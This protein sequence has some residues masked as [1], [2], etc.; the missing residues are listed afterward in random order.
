MNIKKNNY[1]PNN[2][3]LDLFGISLILSLKPFIF[4]TA[5]AHAAIGGNAYKHTRPVNDENNKIKSI[6][7]RCINYVCTSQALMVS[8]PASAAIM[9][10]RPVPVPMSKALTVFP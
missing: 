8:A 6:N 5:S 2:T 9:D 4:N 3:S 1:L 10:R 7:K